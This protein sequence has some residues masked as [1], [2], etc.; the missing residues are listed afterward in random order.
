[1]S[2][3]HTPGPWKATQFGRCWAIGPEASDN[4]RDDICRIGLEAAYAESAANA[5]LIAEAPAM[6]A[7]LREVYALL[8]NPD[9]DQF[10]ADKVELTVAAILARIDGGAA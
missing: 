3:K 8:E 9:A 6:L 2:T 1:M 5:R 7:A 10:D 4:E